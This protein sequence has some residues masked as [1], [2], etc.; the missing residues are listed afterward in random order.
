MV[1]VTDKVDQRDSCS[2][3]LEGVDQ[4][5]ANPIQVVQ[6]LSGIKNWQWRVVSIRRPS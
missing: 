1:P 6:K 5:G 3:K 4:E 2:L